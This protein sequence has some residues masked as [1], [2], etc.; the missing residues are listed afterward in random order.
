MEFER[1]VSEWFDGHYRE[2]PQRMRDALVRYVVD[3]V[4]PGS[5]LTAVICNDLA[6]AVRLADSENL[7]L[8]K[9][10]VEWLYNVP[11]SACK[12]S[13]AAMVAWLE[14]KPATV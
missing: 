4:Q 12:G 6:G 8:L 5:F 14:Q 3:H 9:T 7:P 11:P 10:Y 13:K 1:P 2:I